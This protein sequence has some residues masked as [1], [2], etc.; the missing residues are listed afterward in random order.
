MLL[1]IIL[2]SGCVQQEKEIKFSITN[3]LND[4]IYIADGGYSSG[5]VSIYKYEQGNWTFLKTRESCG[6]CGA[7]SPLALEL[8]SSLTFSEVWDGS[9]YVYNESE[10]NNKAFSCE[11]RVLAGQGRYKAKIWYS[12]EVENPTI[13]R[14]DTNK[15][16]RSLKNPIT[17]I[18][19]EFELKEGNQTIEI[20]IQ[21]SECTTNSDCATGGCSNQICGKKGEVEDIITTCEWQSSYDCLRLTSCSC[22]ENKCEWRETDEYKECLN[23]SEQPEIL[24]NDSIKMKD[25]Y[26]SSETINASIDIKK[27]VFVGAEPWVLYKYENGNWI[28]WNWNPGWM[29]IIGC[30]ENLT[31]CGNVVACSPLYE[32]CRLLNESQWQWDQK[33]VVLKT[34]TCE[35]VSTNKTVQWNCGEKQMSSPGRYKITFN[36]AIDCPYKS[37]IGTNTTMH[38]V[39]KEFTLY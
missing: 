28:Y 13:V 34:I 25:Y 24:S 4:T 10:C 33:T 22:I 12:Y 20:N 30:S 6:T 15:I 2:I 8:N 17:Y 35:S 26:F 31:S 9:Y 18:E 7:K 38:S 3:N 21:K 11:S 37:Y 27:P 5:F 29:C 39:E 16:P 32:G 36:Y 19:K 23:N 1:G 14:W